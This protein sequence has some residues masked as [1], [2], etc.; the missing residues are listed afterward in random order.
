MREMDCNHILTH[1]ARNPRSYFLSLHELHYM[2][3]VCAPECTILHGGETM[4]H[5]KVVQAV[6]D[7][8]TNGPV[9]ISKKLVAIKPLIQAP[10][11]VQVIVSITIL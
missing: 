5:F 3:S 9:T 1:T 11:V 10:L 8:M 7:N 6:R 2:I 4:S